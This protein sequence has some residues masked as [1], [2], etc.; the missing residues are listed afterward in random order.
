M[1]AAAKVEEE[2]RHG[3]QPGPAQYNVGEQVQALSSHPKAPVAS[4]GSQQRQC[5]TK[6]VSE[7]DN[8]AWHTISAPI[9]NAVL[10]LLSTMTLHATSY[11]QTHHQPCVWQS[12]GPVQHRR[13]V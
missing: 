13:W 1:C 11:L 5:S 6:D 8:A 9:I 3:R 7:Y 2:E 4:F 12:A 10:A